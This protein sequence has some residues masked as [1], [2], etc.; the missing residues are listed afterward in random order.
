MEKTRE[1]GNNQGSWHNNKKTE[2]T[3]TLAYSILSTGKQRLDTW[4]TLLPCT[5]WVVCK[6]AA[7]EDGEQRQPEHPFG[8]AL[9]ASPVVHKVTLPVQARQQANV[10]SRMKNT[11][12]VMDQRQSKGGHKSKAGC[13]GLG[14]GLDPNGT[15][16]PAT[17]TRL[18][19]ACHP[20]SSSTGRT[21]WAGP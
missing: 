19:P 11:E 8:T 1:E 2:Q 6:H 5:P 17:R 21:A 18:P 12:V 20:P 9:G 3:K 15:N 10:D 7:N 4:G 13:K 14:E 16:T